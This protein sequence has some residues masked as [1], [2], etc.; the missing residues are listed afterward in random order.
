MKS[1]H[2]D[3]AA[4]LL[5][6]QAGDSRTQLGGGLVGEGDG[7]DLPRPDAA[8]ADE[9]CDAMS[10]DARLAA[11]RPGQDEDWAVC[12]LNR[13]LLLRVQTSQDSLREGVR[14][15]LPLGQGDR[16]GLERGCLYRLDSRRVERLRRS[17]VGRRRQLVRA[18]RK[19][20]LEARCKTVRIGSEL[21]ALRPGV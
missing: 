13:P 8:D 16:L 1:A 9:I 4:R 12:R 3:F 10:E 14:G 19:K 15:G 20:R 5:A 11:A 2:G 21:A 6:D 17:L 7:E 18:A